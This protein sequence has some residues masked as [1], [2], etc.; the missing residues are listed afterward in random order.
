MSD[1]NGVRCGS[2]LA[3][4]CSNFPLAARD[5]IILSLFD[6]APIGL[7]AE[8]MSEQAQRY[9][10]PG[11]FCN[12]SPTPRPLNPKTGRR[13]VARHTKEIY[14]YIYLYIYISTA[15]NQKNG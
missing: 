14:I 11:A 4:V 13:P 6:F 8:K 2:C 7:G 3:H 15:P 5:E 1:T 12:E 10:S 9:W